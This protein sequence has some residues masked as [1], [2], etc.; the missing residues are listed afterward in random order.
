MR[1]SNVELTLGRYTHV[2]RGQEAEALAKLPD[3]SLPP[4][5]EQKAAAT[6]TDGAEDRPEEAPK[7]FAKYFAKPCRSGGISVDSN[8]Q[9][10]PKTNRQGESPQTSIGGEKLLFSAENEGKR[11]ERDS[12]PRYRLKPVRR[13]SKPLPSAT[14]PSLQ[15]LFD[16]ELCSLSL[17][18]RLLVCGLGG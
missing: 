6:G 1:H 4:K 5:D 16:N 2:Y 14:R 15:F 11:R 18:N 17:Q 3:L 7:N 13:F 12:N 9:A 10:D 8:G